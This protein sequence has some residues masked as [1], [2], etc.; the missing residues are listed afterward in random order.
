MEDGAPLA[1][2]DTMQEGITSLK[3]YFISHWCMA[4]VKDTS[5]HTT[6][7]YTPT[8]ALLKPDRGKGGVILVLLTCTLG[9]YTLLEKRVLYM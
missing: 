7:V 5:P 6:H 2:V 4:S 3:F 9:E 1:S 8:H